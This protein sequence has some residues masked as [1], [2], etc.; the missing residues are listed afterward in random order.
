MSADEYTEEEILQQISESFIS[1]G[2][3]ILRIEKMNDSGIYDIYVKD[4]KKKHNNSEETKFEFFVT[5]R[6]KPVA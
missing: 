6:K 3:E 5:N 2:Y 1:R 4:P